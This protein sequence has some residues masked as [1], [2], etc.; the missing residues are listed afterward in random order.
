M[1]WKSED[2]VVVSA[3]LPPCGS[4]VSN[5]EGSVLNASTWGRLA[6]PLSIFFAQLLSHRLP[7]SDRFSVLRLLSYLAHLTVEE[8][9]VHN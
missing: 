7:Q 2:S 5:V 3:L 1:P 8:C 9:C 4:W 6:N